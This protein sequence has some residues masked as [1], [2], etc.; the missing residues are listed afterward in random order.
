MENQQWFVV[1]MSGVVVAIASLFL[2]IITYTTQ[3]VTYTFNI[4]D[5]VGQKPNV[6][7]VL[8]AGWVPPSSFK[9][10]GVLAGFL[11][12]LAVA[13]VLCAVIGLITLRAQ[14]PNTPQ[15]ALTVAG[16]IGV[17]I[18]SVIAI[19]LVL[20]FGNHYTGDIAL[21]IAPIISPIAMVLSIAAVF[22]RKNRV[23]EQAKQ[24]LLA[25]GLLRRGGDL[26]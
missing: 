25:R 20:A 7:T 12:L 24:D 5:F 21:G 11:G 26:D 17:M 6:N 13:A 22:R 23:A 10:D 4:V 16:L 15:F 8:V 18:P 14:R 2:P 3:G 19:V 1:A 9:I